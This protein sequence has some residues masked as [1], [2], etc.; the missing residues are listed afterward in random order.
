MSERKRVKAVTIVVTT[1]GVAACEAQAWRWAVF[2]G[3]ELLEF[4]VCEE[5]D[6]KPIFLEASA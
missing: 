1:E 6:K 3:K 5:I 2:L 4:W